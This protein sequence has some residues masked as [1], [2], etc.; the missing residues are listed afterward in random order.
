MKASIDGLYN[1]KTYKTNCNQGRHRHRGKTSTLA[2]VRKHCS[3]GSCDAVSTT[4]LSHGGIKSLV[5]S[6]VA[7]LFLYC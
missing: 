2:D 7:E 1:W 5:L 6:I 4:G 3:N